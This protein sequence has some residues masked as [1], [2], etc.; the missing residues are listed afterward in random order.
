MGYFT[1]GT[2]PG[3][4]TL[5]SPANGATSQRADT[6][7]LVWNKVAGAGGY[8]IQLSDSL[9]FSNPVVNDSTIDTM[10]T[11]TK[12][13][14]VQKY[15]WRVL[16]SK[17]GVVGPFSSPDSFTTIMSVPAAPA[18]VSPALSTVSVPRAVTFTWRR[19]S[20]A[21]KYV[22]QVA[23]NS[24]AY[25]SGDSAGDFKNA[26]FDTT[27]TDTTFRLS[28][29]LEPTTTY[30]WH[31]SATDT[32]GNS[33]FSSTWEFKTGTGI[34]AIHET[35]NIPREFSLSQNYPNPFNPST[36]IRYALP[37]AQMVTLKVYN[38]LG[39]EV[40]TLV[41]AAQTA[42]YYQVNFSADRF[43]SGVYFY[44]LRTN[45]FSSIHKMLL[46]K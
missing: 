40:T 11:V 5:L 42:G 14:N 43:A 9:T 32:A 15:Y 45:D 38:I 22:F 1:L 13:S 35:N 36:T 16:A 3:V 25:A 46:L 31:V 19:S 27:L 6:L 10:Q 29:P 33:G 30:Y 4:P 17:G 20:L 44:V 39:Q 18:L 37:K 8:L 2:T 23:L 24:Q 7:V 21:T 28:S 41:D 26:V 12:L 34:T